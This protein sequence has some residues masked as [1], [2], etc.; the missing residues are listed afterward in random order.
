MDN[1]RTKSLDLS[2]GLSL[3]SAPCQ[4][5]INKSAW[6]LCIWYHKYKA[7]FEIVAYWQVLYGE[8]SK[9]VKV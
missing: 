3:F 7:T 4:A 2:M 8:G 6:I 1:I 5:G 9:F